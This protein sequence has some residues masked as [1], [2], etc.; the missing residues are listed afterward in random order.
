MDLKGLALANL[1]RQSGRT[2][3]LIALVAVLS[4]ALSAGSLL[5]ASLAAGLDSLEARL[6]ADILVAPSTARTKANLEDVL[7]EGTPGSFYMSKDFVGKVA[8]REGI[9]AVSPQYY[10]ATVK[11]GCCSM[12]VQI[13]GFDPETDFSIQPWIARSYTSAL[14]REDVLVG[15]NVTGAPGAQIK[16]YGVM[17]TI[18]GKLDET[19]TSLDN[20]V[21]ATNDTVADLIAGSQ[22]QGISVL[23][24][25]DPASVVSTVQ[26]KV[27]DG[28]QPDRVAADINRHVRG[29][30][31]VTSKAM[32]SSVAD[33]IGATS[34]V[35]AGVVAGI[36]VLAL[37][38][39][40][41]AF[42]VLGSRRAKEFAIL[43]VLGA[44]RRSLA[45]VVMTEAL[46]VSAAGALV[47]AALGVAALVLGSGAL[48]D[49]LGLPFLLPGPAVIAG[50]AA[51]TLVLG[52]AVG[53]AASAASAL[54]LSK[55][56]AGQT[57][58]ED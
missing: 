15:C 51:G 3:A 41:V 40:L 23:A 28:Y 30:R 33:S 29:V 52:I 43:R 5:M 49:A 2:A 4:L 58:R 6:G 54:R 55:V 44:S 9:E 22:E 14:G 38:V 47:G 39:L 16:F 27:A 7:V 26:V 1:K 37:V 19:G 42:S 32:T 10:L 12:P 53:C 50:V 45:G 48:E 11:A 57:L 24:E 31:A 18:A 46:V 13:I 17:C 35:A 36:W 21:F 8:A 20:A 25:N 56:D 34:N